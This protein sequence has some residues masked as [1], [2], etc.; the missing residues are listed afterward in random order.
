MKVLVT[1]HRG[2]IGAVLTRMLHQRDHDVTGL[3][4]DIFRSCTFESTLDDTPTMEEDVRDIVVGDLAGFDAVIHL[5]GLSNDPLGDYRPNLTQQINCEA[6]VNL[7]RLAKKAGVRRF[8]FAS[9]CSNYGAA[10]SDFL[11]ESAPFNP[12]TPYG[13]SK[14]EVEHAVAPMADESFSPTFLR[15]STAYGLS[16]RIRFDLVLNNLT[17]WAF[18]TGQIYLKSDGSPWRPIVHVEDIARAYIAA[19]EADRELVHNEAFNV[20]LTTEN[21]QVREIADIVQA[22][23]P[24]SRIEFAPD[25]GPDTRCYRVDCNYIGRRLHAFKPQWTARRGV[26]QLYEAFC[27]VGL[28]L[29]DFEGERFKRIAHVKKL[30]RNGEL[31]DDLRRVSVPTMAVA[32]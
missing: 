6:S 31:D 10:G 9:S 15:A 13:L 3:D 1:G 14:V 28:S 19:L 24:N 25:G 21:Y 12:V 16:P 22:I 23:V 29:E 4:S 32:V 18:T 8:L 2:Y 20:G 17:A 30:I 26:E 5:A 27:S 7:A 11:T